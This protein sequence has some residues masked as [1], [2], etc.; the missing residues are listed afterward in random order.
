[1]TTALKAW[2]SVLVV[3]SGSLGYWNYELYQANIKQARDIKQLEE[4]AEA[5]ENVRAEVMAEVEEALGT[6]AAQLMAAANAVEGRIQTLEDEIDSMQGM[7]WGIGSRDL[8]AIDAD[9]D[10]AEGDIANL[11]T[12]MPHVEQL[13]QRVQALENCVDRVTSG[14]DYAFYC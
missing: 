13:R 10:V 4:Q 7:Q 6:G 2:I 8:G 12:Y 1:M 9:L 5:I 11:W 3:V 14:Y